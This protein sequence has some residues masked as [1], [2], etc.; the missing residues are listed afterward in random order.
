MSLANS[1]ITYKNHASG[2]G[3]SRSAAS[4]QIMRNHRA[5]YHETA[6]VQ[7]REMIREEAAEYPLQNPARN[8][9]V[10]SRLGLAPSW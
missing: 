2:Y 4:V 1:I 8:A 3:S 6:R 10:R 7:D 5:G 9:F